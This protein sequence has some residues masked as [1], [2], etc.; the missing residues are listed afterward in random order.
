M[1]KKR[2]VPN[3]EPLDEGMSEEEYIETLQ[4][5]YN[6]DSDENENITLDDAIND[7]I[8][9]EL[10]NPVDPDNDDAMTLAVKQSSFIQAHERMIVKQGEIITT[11]RTMTPVSFEDMASLVAAYQAVNDFCVLLAEQVLLAKT[12]REVKGFNKF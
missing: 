9:T 8:P 4:P 2:E 3:N 7:I 6:S 10:N 5:D 11:I 1:T 12:V